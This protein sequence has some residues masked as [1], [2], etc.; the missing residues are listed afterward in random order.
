[1][2]VV[3]QIYMLLLY[4]TETKL[5][6]NYMLCLQFIVMWQILSAR[7]RKNVAVND[8]KVDVCV[9]AFDVHTSK[10][11]SFARNHEKFVN[12]YDL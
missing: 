11:I 3:L 10:G 2:F 6:R 1:M 5:D 7:R 9:F 12:P 4:N 8:I